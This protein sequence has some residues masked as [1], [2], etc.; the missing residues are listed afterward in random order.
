VPLSA[1]AT[2]S[3]NG[4]IASTSTRNSRAFDIYTMNPDGSSPTRLTDDQGH[5]H[6]PDGPSYDLDQA[7][8]PDGS[9][10]A[11]TSNRDGDSFEIYTMNA[12]GSNVQRL[13]T[14]MTDDFQPAW[15]PD[16][17]R[18]AYTHGGSC[19]T[20]LTK[21]QRRSPA[22]DEPCVAY[23]FLMNSD[24]SNQVK[25]STMAGETGPVWSPDGSRIAFTLSQS[26]VP[27]DYGIYVVNADGSHRVRLTD[28]TAIDFVTS[29]SPDGSKLAFASNRDT[30]QTGAYRFQLYTMNVDGSN[31]R[32]LTNNS[33]DDNYPVFSPDGTRMAFQRG[34]SSPVNPADNTEI[35]V[36]NTDGSNQTNITNNK[37][38]DFGPPAWQPLSAPPQI[39]PPGILQFDAA[40]YS[41]NENA[42]SLAVTVS[43]SG[44]TTEAATVQYETADDTAR[45]RSDYTSAFGTL[46]F[47]A[48]EASK[49]LS[50]MITDDVFVEPTET[51]SLSLHDLTGNTIISGSAQVVVSIMDNDTAPAT[52][53]PL[54]ATQFFV[55]Q[56]YHDFFNREPDSSGFAFW[57]NNIESCGTDARCREVKKIDTSAAFFLSIEFQQTGY[58]VYRLY[59]GSLV[60]TPNYADFVR[61]T[62]EINHDLIVGSPG[63][64]TQLDAN[65]QK[66]TEAFVSTPIFRSSYPEGMSA[67]NYV[68]RIYSHPFMTA[69]PAER[70]QAI[71]A[72]GSGD[73]AGRARALRIVANN[74]AFRQRVLNQSFV[75]MQYYGYLRRNPDLSGYN[76]WLS[77]LDQFN[78]DFRKAEMVKAFIASGEYRQRFGPQ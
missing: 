76:Y 9:K 68:D 43:R 29:W 10:L 63:W 75:L 7:W 39:P 56:H 77:K 48:G 70:A 74:P 35:F 59:T 73:T 60:V 45:E 13:T 30:A 65:T 3:F 61:D 37:A 1:S 21:P 19:L 17:T 51:I 11:F 31:P 50:I 16:G 55:R 72:Y 47:G 15:S 69:T 18:I 14:N 71:A 28:N 64:E 57:V 5:A 26:N 34:Q 54:E 33:F 25:V 8:S 40:S 27:A 36:M 58:Y 20:I 4:R 32:R 52:T 2:G 66:F 42:G 78:G 44:N 22:D 12:D 6:N 62:Q 23:I 38:D 53:N 67:E 24:G 49:S 46:N 41:V